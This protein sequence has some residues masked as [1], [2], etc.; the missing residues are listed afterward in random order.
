VKR[1]EH[2]FH[3]SEQETDDPQSYF[4]GT[5]KIPISCSNSRHLPL[6]AAVSETQMIALFANVERHAYCT[7]GQLTAATVLTTA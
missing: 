5:N 3:M 1:F 4:A 2:T 6:A 7:P